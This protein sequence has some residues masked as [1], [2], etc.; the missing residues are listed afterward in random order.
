MLRLEGAFFR[1]HRH[2]KRTTRERRTDRANAYDVTESCPPRVLDYTPHGRRAQVA[3]Q[4]T[5]RQ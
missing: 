2:H 1:G 4:A 3:H 5:V